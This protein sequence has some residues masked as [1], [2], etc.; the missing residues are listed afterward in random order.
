MADTPQKN[1]CI[2]CGKEAGGGQVFCPACT[3]VFGITA[4]KAN[5]PAGSAGEIRAG[6]PPAMRRQENPPALDAPDIRME[7][8]TAVGCMLVLGSVAVIFGV[9]Y[10][11]MRSGLP[12]MIAIA[13]PML[14]GAVCYAIGAGV[15]N[16][17]GIRLY[18][19][20][21]PSRDDNADRAAR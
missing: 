8:P 16:L 17:L 4:T 19:D 11:V 3:N 13:I 18:R 2:H 21:H 10:P 15:C 14:A 12:Q 20:R 1:V 9:A 5:A 6:E 7:P